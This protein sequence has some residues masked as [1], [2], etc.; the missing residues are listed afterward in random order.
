M[1]G[2]CMDLRNFSM[3]DSNS[4]IVCSDST[5][6]ISIA[7]HSFISAGTIATSLVAAM[8]SLSSANLEA[9]SILALEG[10]S[11]PASNPSINLHVSKETNVWYYN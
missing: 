1:N 10:A 11:S 4:N 8:V 2:N 5:P 9:L 6:A 7:L 3:F